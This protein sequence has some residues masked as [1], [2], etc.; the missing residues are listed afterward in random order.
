MRKHALF[1]LVT[2]AVL[3]VGLAPATA[4]AAP[5][6]ARAS[7]GTEEPGRGPTEPLPDETFAAPAGAPN[8]AHR[9]EG[10]LTLFGESHEG[11]F[12]ELRD[13]YAMAG[14]GDEPIKHLPEIS[15]EF[16]GDGGHLIPRVQGLTFTGHPDWNLIVGPGR[17]WQQT[18][19]GGW[20]KAAF[21]FSLV[22]R[23][24]NC[25]H[26]GSMSF[27]Y[28]G[29]SVSRVRYQVTQETCSFFNFDMWGSLAAQYQ[30]YAVPGAGALK[31]AHA[32]EVA[33]RL[34]TKPFAQLA[35]DHPGVD[36]DAFTREVGAQ[37]LTAYGVL[38]QGVNYV[39]GCQTRWGTYAFCENMRFPSFS[40]SKT[41]LAAFAQMRLAQRYGLGAGAEP[42]ADHVPETA[43]APGRWDD[44]TVEH[45][46]DMATGN[47][48]SPVRMADED[49]NLIPFLL[50]GTQQQKT[51][52]A[53]GYPRSAAPGTQWVYH[54][55]DT[56]LATLAMQGYLRERAGASADLFRMV[57][58]EVYAP[59]KLSAGIRAEAMRADHSGSGPALGGI[60]LFWN[61]DDI[62]K[63]AK[64]MNDDG[65]RAGGVQLLHP[66]PLD[67]AMQRNPADRGL[68]T[69]SPTTLYNNG[70][71]ARVFTPTG[72][73][74]Y[75]C[76]FRVPYMSGFGGITAAMMPNGVTYYYFSDNYGYS[77]TDA[78]HA[79][80]RIAPHCP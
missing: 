3:M 26:N 61:T 8:P 34:P 69:T 76:T 7:A 68:T 78:V 71:W 74:Q 37:H 31:A 66:D 51:S 65:G 73:P 4:T 9:F 20:S 23:F 48:T 56:Y 6:S 38:Y 41:A 52:L 42:I 25:V 46:L 40:T 36:P 5:G 60:G 14:P 80:D 15:V 10:R 16:V 62:A 43:T 79:A 11:G 67:R 50:A 2:A 77:W 70:T 72:F 54:T 13:P 59:I 19:A 35:V 49:A 47:Y 58:D 21:P 45:A 12:T 18:G 1:P 64:L 32:A 57:S 63:V 24:T 39:G 53:L 30:P 33:N 44:V 28:N 55:T 22:P 27:H 17:A 75:S 29:S